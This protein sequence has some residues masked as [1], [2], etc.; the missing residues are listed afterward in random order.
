MINIFVNIRTKS[1]PTFTKF[2]TI[3]IDTVKIKNDI[4]KKNIS[5]TGG[6]F[7]VLSKLNSV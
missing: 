7:S 1:N 6:Y 4:K 2:G 3:V 5:C